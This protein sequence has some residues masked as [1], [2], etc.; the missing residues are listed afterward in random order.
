MNAFAGPNPRIIGAKVYALNLT[1][2]LAPARSRGELETVSEVVDAYH[3]TIRTEE[4]NVYSNG[5]F[6][7][8]SFA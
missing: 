3:G 5:A 6:G 2:G 4:G 1:H 8:Q 7:I